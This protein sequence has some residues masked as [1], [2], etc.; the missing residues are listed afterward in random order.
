[1]LWGGTQHLPLPFFLIESKKIFMF[2]VEY[3]IFHLRESLLQS[4][5]PCVSLVLVVISCFHDE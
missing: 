2:H 5:L 3:I 1:M 4:L